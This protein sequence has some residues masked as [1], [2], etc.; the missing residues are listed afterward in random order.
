MSDDATECE[1]IEFNKFGETNVELAFD[2]EDI[3]KSALNFLQ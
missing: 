2:H 1:W 3:I